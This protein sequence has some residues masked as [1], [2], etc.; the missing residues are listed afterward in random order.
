V[1]PP[2]LKVGPRMPISQGMSTELNESSTESRKAPLGERVRS[3]WW[4]GVD[5]PAVDASGHPLSNTMK[6][7]LRSMVGHASEIERAAAKDGIRIRRGALDSATRVVG[8][9]ERLE[10]ELTRVEVEYAN[11]LMSLRS[12]LTALREKLEAETAA[13]ERSADG[14]VVTP[15]NGLSANVASSA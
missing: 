6:T 14:S 7:H 3:W 9:V 13:A 1:R 11:V 5:A 2:T 10:A 8:H 12:E 4:R 15:L